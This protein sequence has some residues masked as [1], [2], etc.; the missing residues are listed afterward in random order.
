MS[1][2]HIVTASTAWDSEASADPITDM[3]TWVDLIAADLSVDGKWFHVNKKTF[4]KMQKIDLWQNYMLDHYGPLA[5]P[6]AEMMAKVMNLEGGIV[7][8]NGYW[9]DIDGSINRYIPDG[10]ALLTSDYVVDDAPIAQVYDGPVV[11]AD[12]AGNLRVANNSGMQVEIFA[13]PKSKTQYI[14]L[15]TARIPWIRR[16]AFVWC[17]LYDA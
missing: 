7:I 8:E 11:L 3:E 14:R 9:E 2:S 4:R 16:E 10:Y 5:I 17:K 1:A 12:G 15:S 6:T 13:D